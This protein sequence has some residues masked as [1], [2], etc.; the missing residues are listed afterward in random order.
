MTRMHRTIAVTLILTACG[1]TFGI[2]NLG[3]PVVR[4]HGAAVAGQSPENTTVPKVVHEVKPVYPRDAMAKGITG[5][6]HVD[7]SIDERGTVTNT[8]IVKS[9]PELDEA[10]MTA[11]RQWKF[12]PARRD[13]KAV[14]VT[15]TILTTFRLK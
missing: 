6:V 1:M 10:A 15:V 12:E 2:T 9:I 13:G 4:V 5:D 11:L 14:P 8:A 7:V 3:V